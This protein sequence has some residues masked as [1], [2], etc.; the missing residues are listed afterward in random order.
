MLSSVRGGLI[1]GD[2]VTLSHG[3]TV[4]TVGLDT[5]DYISNSEKKYRDHVKRP[6]II[7]E[8]T[9]VAANVTICPGA[10]IP[11]RCIVAAGAVVSGA[12]QEP[13]CLY[14]GIPAKYIK[15]IT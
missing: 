13:D 15:K 3:V 1:I 8:G 14:G 12:L 6:V 10:T 2:R 4:L 5:T 7:G 9:W 11:E